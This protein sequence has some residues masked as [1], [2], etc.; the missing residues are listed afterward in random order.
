MK[1]FL[2]YELSGMVYIIWVAVFYFSSC[3]GMLFFQGLQF[4]DE[5]GKAGK[6]EIKDLKYFGA[7]FSGVAVMAVMVA[8]PIGSLIHQFSVLIKNCVFGN[9]K[10]YWGGW[11]AVGFLIFISLVVAFCF[12]GFSL[13]I[14]IFMFIE[15]V[16]LLGYLFHITVGN[17]AYLLSDFPDKTTIKKLDE[18]KE[19]ASYALERISN[20]NSFYYI[21]FDNGVLAPFLAYLTVVVFLEGDIRMPIVGLA[22]GI[23][24]VTVIY[25]PRIV[26]EIGEYK[27]VIS[28]VPLRTFVKRRNHPENHHSHRG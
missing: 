4:V 13:F 3:D 22:F 14:G 23:A 21:R 17:P 24:V 20:L 12:T 2:R 28:S 7:L 1:Q 18:N 19:I 27:Q 5:S 9:F 8:F 10:F 15:L 16:L 26:K 6:I 25:I 11:C